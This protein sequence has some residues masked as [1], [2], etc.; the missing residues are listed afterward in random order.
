MPQYYYFKYLVDAFIEL[1]YERDSSIRGA[2]FDFRYFRMKALPFEARKNLTRRFSPKR[3]APNEQEEFFVNLKQLIETTYLENGKK[4]VILIS[5]SMGSL[6]LLNLLN[7]K[8]DESWKNRYISTWFAISSPWTGSI[9][10]LKTMVTG[11]NMGIFLFNDKR[12]K[13]MER[14]F[15]GIAFLLPNPSKFGY[16]SPVVSLVAL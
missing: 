7:L 4:K 6:Y 14:T 12:F 2:P 10:A 5:H 1:G 3:L 13:D 16:D 9:R 15:P 8:V 11:D